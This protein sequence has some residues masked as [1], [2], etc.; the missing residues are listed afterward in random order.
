MFAVERLP[1]GQRI[2][3]GSG[4]PQ[5]ASVRRDLLRVAAAA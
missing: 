4:S 2:V 5:P 3:T 1:C